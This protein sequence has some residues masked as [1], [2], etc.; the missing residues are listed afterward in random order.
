MND[1][2]EKRMQ[3]LTQADIL[4]IEMVSIANKFIESFRSQASSCGLIAHEGGIFQDRFVY[5]NYLDDFYKKI[6]NFSERDDLDKKISEALKNGGQIDVDLDSP[7][8]V[9]Y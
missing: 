7:A 3:V 8:L 1:D 2:D 9:Y 4:Q 5:Q 6:D